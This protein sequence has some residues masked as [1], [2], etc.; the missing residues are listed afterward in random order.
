MR[1][2]ADQFGSGRARQ[3]GAESVK[4]IKA[5]ANE[6]LR[7][8]VER[9]REEQL[10][11]QIEE[12]KMAEAKAKAVLIVKGVRPILAEIK[13]EYNQYKRALAIRDKDEANAVYKQLIA[14]RSKLSDSTKFMR[15]LNPFESKAD[16][17]LLN[18][19][20]AI[21]EQAFIIGISFEI[22]KE[23]L[24]EKVPFEKVLP[25]YRREM[26]SKR[27]KKLSDILGK[28]EKLGESPKSP[29][30]WPEETLGKLRAQRIKERRERGLPDVP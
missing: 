22:Q 19:A 7:M 6:R 10:A 8:R 23:M 29:S 5:R 16:A 17:Y 25:E 24:E 11:K 26:A 9:I 14:S 13:R 21:G 28:Y 15:D 18:L 12:K 27:L 1:I 2:R 3:T 4:T 20:H 30:K